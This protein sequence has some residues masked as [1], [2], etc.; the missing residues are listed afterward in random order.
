MRKPGASFDLGTNSE[1]AHSGHSR[2]STCSLAVASTIWLLLPSWIQHRGQSGSVAVASYAASLCLA[3]W[4]LLV[5]GFKYV[6]AAGADCICPT[7][8]EG[9]VTR[10]LI[11]LSSVQIS[12]AR[13][14]RRAARI[15]CQWGTARPSDVGRQQILC[16]FGCG[17][18]VCDIAQRDFSWRLENGQRL[19]SAK[20]TECLLTWSAS[21]GLDQEAG[22]NRP[23]VTC[24][25]RHMCTA[26]FAELP[27]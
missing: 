10:P 20:S 2:K 4:G 6:V 9:P 7:A 25:L 8:G 15:D 21:P 26:Q 16:S 11:A 18:R 14:C 3:R 1:N 5:C 13:A 27:S 24:V 17:R 12:R 22:E 23:P 19:S